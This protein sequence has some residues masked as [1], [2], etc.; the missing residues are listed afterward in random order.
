M[1]SALISRE[2]IDLKSKRHQAEKNKQ[3]RKTSRKSN[4]RPKC[5]FKMSYFPITYLPDHVMFKI[6]GYLS[7][8]DVAKLRIVNILWVKICYKI[9]L[10]IWLKIFIYSFNRMCIQHLNN[11]FYKVEKVQSNFLKDLRSKLPRRE[12]A[13]KNHAYARH[14]D[15]L[16]AID[17]R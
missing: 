6:L 4:Y 12:S 1:I 17:T 3:N 10:K 2:W 15:I 8:D 14:C 13:R 9:A 16:T 7:Y 5:N 11:G